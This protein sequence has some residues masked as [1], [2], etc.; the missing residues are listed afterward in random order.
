[1]K[2]RRWTAVLLAAA[3]AAAPAALLAGCKEKAPKAGPEPELKR[4]DVQF[5]DLFDTVTSMVGY[6]EDEE[7][8]RRYAQELYDQLKEYHQL[9]DIYNDY[10]GMANIKTIN[11]QAGTAPVKVDERIIGMLKEAVKMDE[12]TDG[13]MNVA[14]GSVLSLWHEYRTEGIENPEE[15]ALPPMDRLR[16]AAE[17]TDIGQVV[18]DEEASTVYLPDPDMSLDVG[19][20]AKGYAAEMVCRKLEED[21]LTKALVSVG[22]NVR[23][24]GSRG[25]NTRWRVGIQNPDLSSDTKYLY[26][27]ELEDMSLVTSGSYQ[28]YYT[29]D[30]KEYHHIIHPEL[31]MPW[32]EY[33]SVSILCRD[34]GMADCLSTAVFNMEFEDGKK[35]IESLDQV[36][37]M[38]IFQDGREEYSSGFRAFIVEE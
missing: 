38:W 9:Y 7:T 2:K 1:M 12:T 33:D 35:L 21:G 30:G 14:M 24:I 22:G 4:Y 17:H 23:A 36:E 3:V 28:R 10:E 15:A 31:L 13:Y 6:A 5:L 20:V 32:D 8:F 27:V 11:D 25:D 29:V 16:E 37:A 19:S 26:A 18:I 34:S